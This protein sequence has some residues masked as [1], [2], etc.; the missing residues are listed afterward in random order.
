MHLWQAW[1]VLEHKSGRL[2]EA[3]RLFSHGLAVAPT[4]A[5]I[6]H[7]WGLL[8]MESASS[9]SSSSSSSSGSSSVAMGEAAR[10]EFVGIVQQHVCRKFLFADAQ[11]KALLPTTHDRDSAPPESQQQQQQ[12]QQQEEEGRAAGAA[13]AGGGGGGGGGGQEASARGA[14]PPLPDLSSINGGGGGGEDAG[15]AAAWCAEWFAFVDENGDGEL[16]QQEVARGMVRTLQLDE[17]MTMECALQ[18][19]DLKT[20]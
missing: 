14:H 5:Y 8:E 2:A 3:R 1:A 10:L 17:V 11:G 12:Q 4:N 15:A 13:A 7:A 19:C 6:C 18:I 16:S 20:E 9:S